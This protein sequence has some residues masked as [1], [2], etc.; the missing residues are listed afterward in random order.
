[1]H[2]WQSVNCFPVRQH[3]VLAI[4]PCQPLRVAIFTASRSKQGSSIVHVC[5]HGHQITRHLQSTVAPTIPYKSLPWVDAVSHLPATSHFH[6]CNTLRIAQY[7]WSN[8]HDAFH[9]IVAKHIQHNLPNYQQ[10]RRPNRQFAFSSLMM[11]THA[12]QAAKYTTH[13]PFH[14]T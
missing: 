3:I 9:S 8:L 10:N 6:N 1:M 2:T 7:M 14:A 5:N 13:L 11:S 12:E 4:I